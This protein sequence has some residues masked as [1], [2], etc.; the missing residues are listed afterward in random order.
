MLRETFLQYGWYLEGRRVEGCPAEAAG[1]KGEANGVKK[2][3]GRP[4]KANNVASSQA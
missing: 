2:Q 1:G 3:P 4:R